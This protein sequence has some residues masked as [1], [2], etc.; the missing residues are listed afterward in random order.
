MEV[1]C[2][3]RLLDERGEPLEGLVVALE[4][5]EG[6]PRIRLAQATSGR[7]GTYALRAEADAWDAPQG[8]AVAVYDALGLRPLLRVPVA[9]DT[10][11]GVIDP[12]TVPRR[13]VSGW[14]ATRTG[15]PT[16][17]RLSEGNALEL[18][19]DDALFV[20]VSDAISRARRSISLTQ[21]LFDRDF[22]TSRSFH[23]R[24][25]L[26]D[27]LIGA[28]RRGVDVRILLNDNAI[29]P[30]S[31]AE[32]EQAALDAD[33]PRV[34][35]RRFP[36]SPNVLHAKFLIIDEQ[37]ALIV[38]APFQQSYW[39]T[40]RHDVH[41]P[42]RG[43]RNQPVHDVAVRMR[44][45]IVAHAHEAF[46]NLWNSRSD[47]AYGG[48]DRILPVSPPPQVGRAALQLVQ[49]IPPQ[50]LPTAPDGETTILQ[51]YLRGIAQARDYVYMENQYFTNPTVSEA[52][53]RALR[54]RPS[55]Q[56]I[57]V[58]NEDT[59]V[60]TYVRWQKRRLAE[61]G[62]PG[63]P[64]LGVFVLRSPSPIYVHSK[65]ALVDDAWATIGT[66][67]LDSMSLET[68]DEFAAPFHPNFD[69]NVVLL[70]GI[71]G[72]PRTG[73]VTETRRRLWAEHLG[74]PPEVFGAR[75]DGGWLALWERVARENAQR[76]A[77]GEPMKGHAVPYAPA[78]I[79]PPGGRG[80]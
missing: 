61:L 59:D 46:A 40:P 57:L 45:P 1:R 52:L 9:A 30:D 13:L 80:D 63:R 55:L 34:R 76:L 5:R 11:R 41:E 74:D 3:G 66:A 16:P 75:P 17:V 71:E 20:A 49:T 18:F 51:A 33:V 22:S 62:H 7:D 15:N 2:E 72:A 29:V 47:A 73:Q 12:V 79:Q 27:E 36:I 43:K 58:I 39:D 77:R 6:L 10:R 54:L 32:I 48:D 67:N 42:R 64:R 50:V 56:V 44:G 35:V 78:D 38:G 23:H 69:A 26:V 24:P 4:D 53:S 8:I 21:L 25:A 19:V 14:L 68:A 31:C 37:E 65:L 60:P 28:G 70:D